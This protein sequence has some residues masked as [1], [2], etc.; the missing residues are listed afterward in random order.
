[1]VIS[2]ALVTDAQASL[3]PSRGKKVIA[4]PVEISAWIPYWRKATGT[5]EALAHIK[6][7]TELSPFAYTVKSDGT[8][9]DAMKIEEEP[10][11]TFIATAKENKVKI[12]PSILWTN[13][14]SIDKILRNSKLRKNHVN[15][16]VA[17]VKSHNFDGVDIDYEGKDAKTK[18]YFSLF[19]HDLWYAIGKKVVSCTI[20]ARTPL[21]ARFET[22]P[23]NIEYANDYV[24]INK[25]CDRVRIMTYDQGTID[26]KLN[27]SATGP[28]V[29]VADV[30]WVEKVINLAKQNISK[31]KIVLGVATYGYEYTVAPTLS[32]GY[33]Y[34]RETAFNP[35][36]A[37]DIAAQL[38]IVPT[39]NRAGELSFTYTPTS[40]ALV[41]SR[42][43]QGTTTPSLDTGIFA[44]TKVTNSMGSTTFGVASTTSTEQ[45]FRLLWWSDAQAIQD[46][47]TLAKKLGVRG[48]AIFKIDGG[49]GPDLWNVTR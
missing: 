1:M 18:K 28:Y 5:A 24:A 43:P 27:A 14:D 44:E 21:D 30:R 23:A 33:L 41:I 19:L 42:L 48:V 11:V 16:I 12:I 3:S 45:A 46:K 35:K 31:N 39:R 40:T 17:M 2:V 25:Y 9:F 34:Q 6:F 4:Q 7:F 15:A 36:Y 29:P 37:Q 49:V 8:L 32:G 22:I 10:W 20:E 13:T 26:L 47:I 38:N